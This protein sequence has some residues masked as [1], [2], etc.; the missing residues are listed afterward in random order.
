M[1]AINAVLYSEK[2]QPDLNV[3]EKI[4][5]DGWTIPALKHLAKR[6]G[7][8][9]EQAKEII[10]NRSVVALERPRRSGKATAMD[11]KRTAQRLRRA[12][13]Y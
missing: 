10:R 12:Y 2:Y 3:V 4:V 7:V 6:W 11:A 13:G 9:M 8:D 1:S 5:V